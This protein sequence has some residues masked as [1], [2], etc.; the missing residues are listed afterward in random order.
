[1]LRWSCEEVVAQISDLPA[2]RFEALVAMAK[3]GSPV[4]GLW[5]IDERYWFSGTGDARLTKAEDDDIRICWTRVL[6]VLADQHVA[7]DLRRRQPGRLMTWFDR[8]AQPRENIRIKGDAAAVLERVFGGDVWLG[9]TVIWNACC[10]GLLA[11][12]LTDD[13]RTSLELG[14]RLA[15][16][17]PTPLD[18]LP[19]IHRNRGGPLGMRAK[20]VIWPADGR[21]SGTGDRGPLITSDGSRRS[22]RS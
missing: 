5:P 22:R 3:G 8:I 10:A 2:K 17:G 9:V 14:W 12:R 4:G 20:T 18:R 19:R 11:T 1:M 21:S 13:L 6:Q 15:D 7:R 16:I